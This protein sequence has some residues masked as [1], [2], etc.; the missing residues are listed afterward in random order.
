MMYNGLCHPMGGVC[1]LLKLIG[2]H[3]EFKEWANPGLT[4]DMLTANQRIVYKSA[5]SPDI[6]EDALPVIAYAVGSTVMS[7]FMPNSVI[8]DS[9]GNVACDMASSVKFK[10]STTSEAL[11]AELG[12]ELGGV[13]MANHKDLQSGGLFVTSVEIS[14][15][16]RDEA[17]YYLVTV[18]VGGQLSRAV[19]KK[20][21][22]SSIFREIDIQLE[23]A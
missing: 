15:T 1:L 6:R 17:G 18:S 13:I 3:L 7:P 8:G 9:K 2:R 11:S 12:L 4:S 20:T 22:S 16:Q 21:K 19:W 10:I 23:D 14:Q 5:A